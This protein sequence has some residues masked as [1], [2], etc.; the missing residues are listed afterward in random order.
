VW[1]PAARTTLRLNAT[2]AEVDFRGPLP[3]YAGPLRRDIQASLQL[4]AEWR[5]LRN[6]TLKASAQRYT[7]SSNDPAGSFDG[8]QFTLDLSFLF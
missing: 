6:L 1:Q 4:E 7:Q 2:R 5:A 8:T 3:T